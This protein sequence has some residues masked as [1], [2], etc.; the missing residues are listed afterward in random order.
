MDD[1]A[2]HFSRQHPLFTGPYHNRDITNKRK[3]GVEVDIVETICFGRRMYEGNSVT[4]RGSKFQTINH[5]SNE[6]QSSHTQYG[7]ACHNASE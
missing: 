1:F 7:V 6:A 3:L 5:R 4:R 2:E